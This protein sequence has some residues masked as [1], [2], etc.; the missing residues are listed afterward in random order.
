MWNLEEFGV[1]P[2]LIDAQGNSCSYDTLG[3]A[4]ERLAAAVG[5]RCLAMILCTNTPGSVLGYTA[6][7]NHHIV[8]ILTAADLDPKLLD[9]LVRQ[10]RPDWIWAPESSDVAGE[11]V[12][13]M[14][15]YVLIKTPWVHAFPLY[16]EL[17][18]LL[19][20]SGSTGSPK[21]VRQSYAN[22]QANTESIVEYL[23]LDATER[24][25]TTLPMNYTYGLSILN[26]HL[27]VGASII[28][29]EASILQKEFWQA[30]RAN[31][32]TSFG[33]VPYT[34]DM[35][36][37]LRF[38]RMD[39]PT[40]RTMTQAGGKLSVELHKKFAEYAQATGREF[41]VM[42]GQTEATARM[43]YLPPEKAVEKCGSMGIAIPGG[44]FHLIDINGDVILEPGI[45]G[46][47]VY[48]GAN[49]TL[50]YAECGTDLSRGD[51]RHAVLSTG[52]MAQMDADGYYY[53]V[54][55]KKRFLKMF[56]SRVNLD[57]TE[58]LIRSAFP[59]LDCACGGMDDQM[60]VFLTDQTQ[61]DSMQKYL[62]ET[63]RLHHSAFHFV[64]LDQIP[65][66]EAG[67]TLYSVL[68]TYY[69]A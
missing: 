16:E 14:W 69:G 41:V 68:N 44:Q 61:K 34:Y 65:R 51:E 60:Y 25:I 21:L 26:S 39:L 62:S 66:N 36:D 58:R 13:S 33:G 12:Y 63:L 15:G 28:M 64:V 19:T 8:P 4:G 59:T 50:G 42:Y 43:A 53:V 5:E 38:L 17:A 48:E 55:R 9:Q 1:Q 67:K 10:Y 30:F 27:Y 56:G 29:T 11:R 20:T 45:T 35:L 47:L 23:H 2:A 24:P 46:E 52:D 54:G 22:I 18:L 3:K 49:V 6:F 57:E 31:G 7:V 40:L 37:K 32:A